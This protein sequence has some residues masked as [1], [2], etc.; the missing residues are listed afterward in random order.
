M[1]PI[2]YNEMIKTRTNK[3]VEDLKSEMVKLG[4]VHKTRPTLKNSIK[5]SYKY[6]YGMINKILFRFKESGVFVH[7]G[8]G[9]GGRGNREEKKWFAPI[10]EAFADDVMNLAADA[11]LTAT[12][13]SINL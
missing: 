13:R 12:L 5:V 4:M 10:V 6:R 9:K 8:V 1:D 3:C 11:F 2:D 7:I